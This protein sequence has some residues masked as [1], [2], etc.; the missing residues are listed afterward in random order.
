[1]LLCAAYGQRGLPMLLM[2]YPFLR[3]FA[4][5]FL[6]FPDI[7]LNEAAIIGLP[8]RTFTSPARNPY[9]PPHL[10]QYQVI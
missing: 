2:Y 6:F 7:A 10:G 4:R 9:L 1:M 5:F 8:D 3:I